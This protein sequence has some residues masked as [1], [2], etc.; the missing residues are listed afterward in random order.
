LAERFNEDFPDR[1]DRLIAEDLREPSTQVDALNP[2]THCSQGASPIWPTSTARFA[3]SHSATS[4]FTASRRSLTASRRTHS[5]P[6]ATVSHTPRKSA[7][8]A[9]AL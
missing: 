6:M 2:S 9:T 1:P 4:L 5:S 8:P 7:S 3:I